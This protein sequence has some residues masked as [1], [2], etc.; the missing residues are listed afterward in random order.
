[1]KVIC[2]NCGKSISKSPRDLKG[3]NHTFCNRKCYIK[4][5]RKHPEEFK[6]THIRGRNARTKTIEIFRHYL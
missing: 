4:Y 3:T 5:R 6:K 1:M 2:D